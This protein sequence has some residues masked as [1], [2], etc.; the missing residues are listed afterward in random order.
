MPRSLSIHNNYLFHV[1]GTLIT[2]PPPE[3]CVAEGD[4]IMIT[5]TRS[6]DL[7]VQSR[8]RVV[9]MN[10]TATGKYCVRICGNT[11]TLSLKQLH[12]MTPF[13]VA[14]CAMFSSSIVIWSVPV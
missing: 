11:C 12:M 6:L 4:T 1:A 3:T 14:C 5:C 2:C 9:S 13:P 7:T 8:I 10:G